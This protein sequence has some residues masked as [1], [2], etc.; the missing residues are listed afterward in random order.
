MALLGH[1]ELSIDVLQP[2]PKKQK[3]AK[4]EEK[5]EQKE[6]SGASGSQK[7]ERGDVMLQVISLTN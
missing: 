7:T 1:N 4:K 2:K 5:P 6:K 3:P